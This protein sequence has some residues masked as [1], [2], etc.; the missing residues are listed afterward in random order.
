MET[1]DA[2]AAQSLSVIFLSRMPA[3][4]DV[5]YLLTRLLLDTGTRDAVRIVFPTAAREHVPAAFK[6]HARSLQQILAVMA[7]VAGT[8][9]WVQLAPWSALS[10][11]EL[12][13]VRAR[14]AAFWVLRSGGPLDPLCE[15]VRSEMTRRPADTRSPPVFVFASTECLFQGLRE[16]ANGT[17]PRGREQTLWWN[18]ATGTLEPSPLANRLL[19]PRYNATVVLVDPRAARTQHILPSPA[20]QARDWGD[21]RNV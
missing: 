13:C 17:E 19:A 5:W 18:F 21:D 6:D 16:R 3:S 9:A 10:V 7:H 14:A 8:V 1:V 2:S 4:L 20:T 11:E 15:L 12:A